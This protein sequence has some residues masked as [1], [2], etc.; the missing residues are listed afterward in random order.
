M[1]E[2]SRETLDAYYAEAAS[3]NSDR[4]QAM[5]S[6]QRIA[7]RIAAGA[8]V[9]AILEAVALAFLM[10]LKTVEPYTLM[11]DRTTGYVQALKPLDQAK[12]APDAALTQAFLAQ[13]VMAREGFDIATLNPNYRKVALLSAEGARSSYLE[14]MQ[15]SN[16]ANPLVIYPRTSVVDV[17]VK[18]VSPIGPGTVLVRFDTVRMDEGAQTQ[19]ANPWV[20]V[21]GYRYTT[22]PMKLEDRLINPLGFQVVRYRRD[23]EAPAPVTA[24]PVVARPASFNNPAAQPI[25]QPMTGAAQ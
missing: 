15:A 7:W 10:P 1:N 16:P 12:I 5:R 23:P 24:N 9:I 22:E 21:I 14:M 8:A 3:W 6:S 19:P 13:Y 18:S 11:V 4:L 17:R 25:G 20:A 2:L